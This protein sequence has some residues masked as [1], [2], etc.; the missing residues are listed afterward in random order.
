MSFK[1]GSR[2]YAR[3]KEGKRKGTIIAELPTFFLAEYRILF[4]DG[5]IRDIDYRALA[6]VSAL[7]ELAEQAE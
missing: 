2:V 5:G 3:H 6:T 4:D 7:E 1:I